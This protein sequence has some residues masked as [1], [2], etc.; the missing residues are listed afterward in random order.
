M[1]MRQA[2]LAAWL[3]APWALAHSAV[4]AAPPELP[5]WRQ[6]GP[7]LEATI[8]DHRGHRVIFVNGVPLAP[9]MYSGTEHSRQTWTGQPRKSLEEFSALGYEMFQTDFWLKYSLRPDGTLDLDAVRRQLAGILEVNPKAKIVIRLNVSA[10][11]WWLRANPSEVCQ[12]TQPDASQ[13]RFNGN[14]AE[15]LASE[16]Y[17]TFA[18]Q[19]CKQFLREL[20][21]TPEGDRVIGV[22]LGGG[23]YGEWHYYGIYSEPD[24]SPPMQRKFVAFALARYGTLQGINTAWHTAFA[25]LDEISVPTF[26]RRH[27]LADGDFRDPRLDRFVIDYYECQQ[28]VVSTLVNRL[29]RITKESWPRP[30]IVGL[31]Y[32]YFYGG[33]TVGAQAS[34]MDIRTLFRSPYVDYFSGPYASRDMRGSGVAR[35][36]VSSVVLNGKL[37]MTEHDGGSHLGNVSG[38]K[39]PNIPENEA[40]SVARMRRNFM[41][42]FTENGGQWWYDFGPKHTSG[43]WSTP[44][45]QA[46]AKALLKRARTSLQTPYAK[47]ADVL[48]VYDMEAFY[49]MRPARTDRLTSKITEAMTDSLLGTG[50][51]IDRVFLMDL[52]QL[53]LSPYKLV[54]FG[55]TF[56]LN[57]SQRAY[58]NERVKIP[59][60]TVV[61]MSGAGYSD[62]QI[63]R[64][65]F[66][67]DLA[68]MAVEKAAATDF[69]P[70]VSLGGQA[71]AMDDRNLLS[72]FKVVDRDA[73]VIGTY[74]SGTPAAARRDIN[75]CHVYYFGVP[76]KVPLDGFKAI[77]AGAGVRSYVEN[78]V[79]K[80]YVS[81]GRGLIAIYSVSGGEKVIR[82][83]N[84]QSVLVSLEPF[85]A[86][87]FD[88]VDGNPLD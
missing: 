58:I 22:H 59:G 19:H 44:A 67:S 1:K 72:R 57:A 65:S 24:A 12:S 28:A 75:D 48:V 86:R 40:Q 17:E 43:G 62:G 6:S 69:E 49:L 46:E 25:S 82:P 61:F 14:T 81:I 2:F 32:G 15:S 37:W 80:D 63:N 3:V 53:D 88:L 45:L 47:P 66:L 27:E 70:K 35:T 84:G 74:S 52:D 18:A 33:F 77:L 60:R 55:N 42:A 9:Q 20:A 78:T 38:S 34:Q 16:K 10:P 76:V 68:G 71:F 29:A 7:P 56:V 87:Y 41:H 54:I 23:V 8:G 4:D 51:A 13:V 36:L 64:T 83:L 50:A 21:Q 39:F 5:R 30:L 26:A 85:S 31:F 79:E 73:E 11:Q